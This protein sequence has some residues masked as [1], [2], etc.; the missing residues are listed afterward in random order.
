MRVFRHPFV[1][2]VAGGVLLFAMVRW[3]PGETAP[4]SELPREIVQIGAGEVAW[5]QE[6]WMRQWQRPATREEMIGLVTTY[7]K[8]ELLAREA[9]AMGLDQD[10]T[11]VR[12]R[13]AQKLSFLLEDTFRLA[14]P[15][16]D[17]LRAFFAQDAARYETAARV[18]FRHVYFDP[19]KRTDADADARATLSA[20]NESGGAWETTGDRLLIESA[21]ADADHHAIASQFGAEFAESV[22]SLS[23]GS[24]HGPIQSAYGAHL[25]CVDVKADAALAIFEDVESRVADDWYL[26]QHR[27]QVARYF[28]KLMDKYEVDVDP[29]VRG[30]VGP[31]DELLPQAIGGASETP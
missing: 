29:A 13:L 22:L 8:E 6:T 18:S 26:Q 20:L 17:E 7:L 24:W 3:T 9:R 5:L 25:V 31:L 23:A 10:D 30:M 4:A 19:E 2:F 15:K 1:H 21:I 16:E 28:A 14:Q 11:L 27:E 12:R